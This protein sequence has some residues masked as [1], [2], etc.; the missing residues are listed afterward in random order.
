MQCNNVKIE[1]LWV[2]VVLAFIL[3][4]AFTVRVLRTKVGLPYLYFW[5]E[6]QTASN[7]IQMLKTG[8]FNPHFFAYGT[9]T[10]YIN[11][12]VDV[13]HYLY[14]LGRP[15]DAKATLN[16]MWDLKTV[17]DTKWHWTISHPSFFF[18]NRLVNAL[19][20]SVTVLFVYLL[21]RNLFTYRWASL[22]SALALSVMG[23]HVGASAIISPDIPT[24]FFVTAVVLSNMV[25][26][27]RVETKYLTWALILC[28]CA[29]ACKYNSGLVLIVPTTSILMVYFNNRSYFD[30]R[31]LKMLVFIPPLTFFICMPYAL[32]D[33]AAFLHGMGSELRH[34]KV[35]GHGGATSEPGW[36]HMLFQYKA[37]KDNIGGIGLGLVL[38]GILNAFRQPKLLLLL[39][40]PIAYFMYM[41][42][43]KV[44][45]HRNF[46]L[47]YPFI[48]V[49]F[50]SAC[51]F[52]YVIA[53]T[54]RDKYQMANWGLM[55]VAT[56]TLIVMWLLTLGWKETQTSLEMSN[57]R[58]SR[59]LIVD[60]IDA[61]NTRKI[62]VASELRMHEWDMKRLSTPHD[63][64]TLPE[65]FSCPSKIS[66]GL[67]LLP[68][69][70]GTVFPSESEKQV[71]K[72]FSG[73]LKAIDQKKIILIEGKKGNE[74]LLDIYSVDPELVVVD[75][76]ELDNC[77]SGNK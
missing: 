59:T 13:I 61:L 60:R 4:F 66:D 47:I 7:A 15:E 54:L 11:Y 44:N 57:A 53:L 21:A 73:K 39:L 68:A 77:T 58:D 27:K 33:S 37:F 70:I 67:V 62:Y 64:L 30:P 6:P 3:I 46:I 20:G 48:A 51:E 40:L 52:I 72:T 65:I 18:W 75:G 12:L 9:L 28:G 26:I 45:F 24:T 43:M 74:T 31:W 29:V 25:F 56:V 22:I 16:F 34:Y 14:L 49:L 2:L 17:W 35:F 42:Q 5:D 69:Q 1:R 41:T 38:L 8:N 63:L 23:V 32:L 71:M 76:A 50:G 19:F 36:Q 10:I 55:G